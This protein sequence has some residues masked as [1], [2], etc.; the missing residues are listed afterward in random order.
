MESEDDDASQ[1]VTVVDG[2]QYMEMIN[3]DDYEDYFER[4]KPKHSQILKD[5]QS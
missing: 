3:W 1:L 5:L 2:V 4:V